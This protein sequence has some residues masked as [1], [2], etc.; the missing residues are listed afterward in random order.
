MD[1]K[2]IT[3]KAKC[4]GCNH[5]INRGRFLNWVEIPYKANWK[6]PISWNLFSDESPR[7]VA[8]LCDVCITN[9]NNADKAIE[10]KNGKILYHSI[11]K[12]TPILKELSVA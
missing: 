5:P 9:K 7:A 11:R 3:R 10:I 4:C 12:L 1:L 2:S 8:I 6:I